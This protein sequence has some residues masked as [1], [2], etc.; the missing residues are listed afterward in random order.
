[1]SVVKFIN[2][3]WF[4]DLAGGS[5]VTRLA[6]QYVYTANSGETVTLTGTGITYDA[7]G[8]MTAGTITAIK[9]M[10]GSI[11]NLTVTGLSYSA[12]AFS[13]L[14]FGLISGQAPIAANIS[15]LESAL[16]AGAD[17]VF[18]SASSDQ[19]YGHTGNDVLWGGG[20]GDWLYG[21]E[22]KD[23]Y[24]G[25]AGSDF[26]SFWDGAHAV[27]IDLTRASGQVRDDGFGQIETA[28]EVEGWVGS[29]FADTMLG[30]AADVTFYGSGGND[31]LTGGSG[32]DTIWGGEGVDR[33]QGGAGQNIL[34]LWVTGAGHAVS[35][36]L[37][38]ITGQI[39]DDGY[40]NTETA[41]GFQDLWGSQYNDTLLGNDRINNFTGNDGADVMMGFGGNDI[42]DGG[43]GND[44]LYV[45]HRS[46]SALWQRRPQCI[47]GRCGCRYVLFRRPYF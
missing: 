22:G 4:A 43:A 5:A 14:A 23:R 16:L 35:V 19:I 15:G 26:V 31:S 42:L 47:R 18:G 24:V 21:G 28:T 36:D 41:T 1:M 33:L 27:M 37:R 40:G 10:T 17:T 2:D 46:G 6:T 45:W 30:G 32:N 9:I 39:L 12:T 7:S 44:T 8:V 11:V 3:G 25:G 13:Q 34:A 29:N 38:K 20:D